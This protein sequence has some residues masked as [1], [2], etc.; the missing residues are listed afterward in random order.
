MDLALE[1][2]HHLDALA[3]NKDAPNNTFQFNFL[4]H[5][6]SYYN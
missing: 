6:V 4:R 2:E 3:Q 5:S 1:P